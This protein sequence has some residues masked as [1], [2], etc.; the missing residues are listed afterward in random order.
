MGLRAYELEKAFAGRPGVQVMSPLNF[1]DPDV[2]GDGVLDGY[3]D[4]DHDDW[5]NI[6]ERSR[7]R[8]AAASFASR[9]SGQT[10]LDGL[11]HRG[12]P[13]QPLP[14]GH[15][16]ALVHAAPALRGAVGAVRRQ[17]RPVAPAVRP[18]AATGG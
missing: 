15:R 17:H 6:D 9:Y 18:T 12:Q 11:L 4:Q 14:A 10:G 1:I 3:D 5:S 16:L 2:D 7:S 13:V 8:L